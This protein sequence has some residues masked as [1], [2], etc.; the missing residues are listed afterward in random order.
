[1]A[2]CGAN[3]ALFAKDAT[4]MS[5][6][7]DLSLSSFVERKLLK[8]MDRSACLSLPLFIYLFINLMH[9]AS[10]ASSKG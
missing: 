2:G 10:K 4:Q 1:M 7:I 6:A 8:N 3:R 5:A 9:H